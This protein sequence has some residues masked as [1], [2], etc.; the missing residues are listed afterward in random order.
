M[1]DPAYRFRCELGPYLLS[2]SFPANKSPLEL[3][4]GAYDLPAQSDQPR[5]YK[6][7]VGL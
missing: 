5:R 1:G 7:P 6:K 2:R 3:F 4:C